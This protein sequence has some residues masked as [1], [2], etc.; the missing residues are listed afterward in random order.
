MA[1]VDAPQLRAHRQLPRRG[2]RHAPQVEWIRVDDR[3]QV[4]LDVI[5]GP[6]FAPLVTRRM[7]SDGEIAASGLAPR[8]Y[9]EETQGRDRATGAA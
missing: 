5:V 3:Y 7:T 6:E 4:H 2:E 9:D 8:R 1:G